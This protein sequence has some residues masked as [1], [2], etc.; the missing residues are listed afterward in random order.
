MIGITHGGE[1]RVPGHAEAAV[2]V[3]IGKFITRG[4]TLMARDVADSE[5]AACKEAG[6]PLAK[7]S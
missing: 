1:R 7:P 4:P 3:G 5:P 2:A 6:K